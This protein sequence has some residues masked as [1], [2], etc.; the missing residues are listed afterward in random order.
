MQRYSG[1]TVVLQTGAIQPGAT[2]TVYETGT[3]TPAA[4]FSDATGLT[5]QAN[6]FT[7]SALS[8]MFSFCA[9]DGVYD[10]LIEKAGYTPYGISQITLIAFVP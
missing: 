3:L 9:A 2:V 6:P 8:A 7:S 1:T 5:A 4:I 10:L